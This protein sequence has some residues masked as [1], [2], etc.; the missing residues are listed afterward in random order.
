MQL[1]CK[2]MIIPIQKPLQLKKKIYKQLPEPDAQLH[3][4][5]QFCVHK[6]TDVL[7]LFKYE[8]HVHIHRLVGCSNYLL[9]IKICFVAFSLTMH[10]YVLLS[11]MLKFPVVLQECSETC[12]G[13]CGLVGWCRPMHQ[14]VSGSIPGR[15]A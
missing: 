6:S 14:K 10:Y 1:S 3:N 12:P 7:S 4:D 15:G 9:I 5:N 13:W 8:Y 11:W 2:T